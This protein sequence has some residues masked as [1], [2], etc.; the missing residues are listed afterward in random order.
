MEK[1]KNDYNDMMQ[2]LKINMSSDSKE[3]QRL[4]AILIELSN[5]NN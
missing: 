1:S 4:L 2:E 3:L 5:K